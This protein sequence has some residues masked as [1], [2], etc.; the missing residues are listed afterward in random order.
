MYEM[1]TSNKRKE[2]NFMSEKKAKRL[3]QRNEVPEE[4]TWDLTKVFKSDE[5]FEKEYQ[6]VKD[7]VQNFRKLQGTMDQGSQRF[8]QIIENFLSIN[9]KFEKVYVYASMKNDQDTTNAK[10]QGYNEMVDALAAE[11]SESISWF[12]PELLELDEDKLKQYFVEKK[13]LKQ[14]EHLIESML[15]MRKHTLDKKSESLLAGASDIFGTSQNVFGILNNA[16]LKFPIVKDDNGDDIQLSH[17]VYG[18]L[19]ESTNREVRKAAF[20]GLYSV[21][22]QFKHTMATTLIGNVKVHNF[23]AR[24]RNYK[25]AREAATTSNHIPTEVYD[26]L[27]EQVHRN[28]PLLHRYVKLRK[29]ILGVDELHMYDMYT[30]L[31]EDSKLTYNYIQAQ[32]E[33]K[34]ALKVLGMDYLTHVSEAFE[35]RWIDVVENKGKRSGAYSSGVY[36]T[37]PYILLNWQDNLENLFTL[38]HEMGHSMHSY[39]TSHNQPYQYG[40]YPI[41]LAEIASTTNENILT[42]YLLKNNNEKDILIYILN[43]YLDGFKGT[44]Y[45]QTQFAEF[46]KWIHEQNSKGVPLTAK[47]ISEYYLELNKKYYGSDVISDPEIA[48][49]WARIPHFYYNFYVYQYATGFAAATTLAENIL[50]G[51]ENKLNKYLIY[52]KAGS[53]K[54]PLEVMKDAGVDMTD[55]SYLEKAFKVFEERLNQLETL[56]SEK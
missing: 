19:I 36:D 55:S 12:E 46:E 26:V 27:L 48:L 3:L 40:D 18:K 43:H 54:Y 33:A 34:K 56:L 37:P 23:K 45:R 13:E 7:E 30:P 39:Y 21:Y 29:K 1:N 17:G 16:D 5:E 38:V 50:S 2:V 22:D 32:I 9:R 44:V 53:S 8:L 47:S 42:D 41:F 49:E 28:L 24:V 14:Y 20:K 10:Y 6:A 4:L 15:V 51:D 52:L 11:F 25:D 35:N 31:I